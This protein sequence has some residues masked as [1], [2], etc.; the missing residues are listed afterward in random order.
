M[1]CDL[2]HVDSFN[3]SCFTL[4]AHAADCDTNKEKDDMFSV[5]KVKKRGVMSNLITAT[6]Y[7][8]NTPTD[9]SVITSS[10]GMCFNRQ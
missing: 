9:T 10:R 5:T 4:C 1:F 7:V 6:I 8:G 2:F 3:A